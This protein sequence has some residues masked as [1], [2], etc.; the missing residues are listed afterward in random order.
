MFF[1]AKSSLKYTYLQLVEGFRQGKQVCQRVIATLGRLDQFQTS[2]TLDCLLQSGTHLFQHSA[3]LST[4]AQTPP[5]P[6]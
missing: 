5:N 1:R 4:P 2:G 3:V 6:G